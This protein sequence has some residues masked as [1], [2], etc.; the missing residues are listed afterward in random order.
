[1]KIIATIVLDIEDKFIDRKSNIEMVKRFLL[2]RIHEGS[3]DENSFRGK[4]ILNII[5]VQAGLIEVT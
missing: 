3:V 2:S 4:L 1:M 5:N